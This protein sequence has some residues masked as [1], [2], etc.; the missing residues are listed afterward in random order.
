MCVSD[1]EQREW[2]GLKRCSISFD[3]VSV[4]V[5]TVTVSITPT[6]SHYLSTH[7]VSHGNSFPPYHNYL[8]HFLP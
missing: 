5:K 4:T 2:K 3:L 6:C 7:S 1:K 8:I